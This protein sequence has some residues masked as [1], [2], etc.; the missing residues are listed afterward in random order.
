GSGFWYR[1]SLVRIQAP[2]PRRFPS[3]RKTRDFQHVH[4]SWESRSKTMSDLTVLLDCLFGKARHLDRLSKE[5][6]RYECSSICFQK[7]R[8]LLVA[9][10]CTEW[11]RHACFGADRGQSEHKRTA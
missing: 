1:H 11:N 9:S 10:P 2:Q 8:S 5:G 3:S 4:V 7:R 6:I